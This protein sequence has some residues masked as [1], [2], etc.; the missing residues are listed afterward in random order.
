MSPSSEDVPD[1]TAVP[2]D[3]RPP[4][5]TSGLRIGTSAAATRGFGAAE[6]A[7]VTEV[8]AE[9]RKPAAAAAATARSRSRVEALAEVNPLCPNLNGGC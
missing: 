6:F 2:N 7:E 9:P 5:V 3:P 4:M 1:E 8:I